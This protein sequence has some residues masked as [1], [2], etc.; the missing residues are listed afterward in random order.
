MLPPMPDAYYRVGAD[1]PVGMVNV[2]FGGSP[3]VRRRL[4]TRS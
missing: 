1:L 4:G 3:T 2:S